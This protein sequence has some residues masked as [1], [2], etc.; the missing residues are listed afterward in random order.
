MAEI[1]SLFQKAQSHGNGSACS[2]PFEFRTPPWKSIYFV[3]VP[4]SRSIR[5][6]S[7]HNKEGVNILPH[8]ETGGYKDLPHFVLKGGESHTIRSMYFYRKN[9]EKMQD[10]YHLAGLIDCLINRTNP[11]LR[12]DLLR[13]MYKKIFD[14]KKRLGIRW[15]GHID[16]VLLPIHPVY[17]DESEYCASLKKAGSMKELYNAVRKGT[18]KMFN[19][20][21]REYV[22]YCPGPGG[23]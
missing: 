17:F 12:T 20:L 22:F 1:I 18:D 21:A 19:I 7:P 15:Y 2:D 13:A 14:I 8:H 16:R 10:I 4:K 5:H 6:K 11:I 3:Q 23:E 9:K